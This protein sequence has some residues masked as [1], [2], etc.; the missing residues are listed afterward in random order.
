MKLYAKKVAG[1]KIVW[2]V[3]RE[4]EDD[5]FIPIREK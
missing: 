4:F 5:E 2:K 1:G 3:V